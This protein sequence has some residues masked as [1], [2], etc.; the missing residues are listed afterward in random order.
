MTT[1]PSLSS[2]PGGP[3][4]P[5]DVPAG[6][7]SVYT[8]VNRSSDLWYAYATPAGHYGLARGSAMPAASAGYRWSQIGP[9]SSLADLVAKFP[10][11]L[12]SH[13]RALGMPAS[14][15]PALIAQLDAGSVLHG[16]GTNY[17]EIGVDKQGQPSP[18]ANTGTTIGSEAVDAGINVPTP[19]LPNIFGVFATLG[20]WKGIGL[21]LAGAAIIVFAAL[22]FRKMV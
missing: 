12:W 2:T 5:V 7:D 21:V 4:R 11:Q 19:K 6:M 10:G 9:A 22:E 16:S 15:D 17:V 20:F 13:L 8:P 1:F 18:H 14:Y 3:S